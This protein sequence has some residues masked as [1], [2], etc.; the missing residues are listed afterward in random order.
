MLSLTRNSITNES[1][2]WAAAGVELP[3]FDYAQ[4][5]KNTKEKPQWVHFGA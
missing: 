4:V 2:A 5:A 3:Q 1:E